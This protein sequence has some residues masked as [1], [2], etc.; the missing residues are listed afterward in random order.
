MEAKE[1]TEEEIVSH[2]SNIIYL[3]FNY[4]IIF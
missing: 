4:I 1:Y 3:I 2:V